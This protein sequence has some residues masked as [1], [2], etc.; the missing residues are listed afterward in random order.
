[1]QGCGGH[2]S[3][4]RTA[5]TTQRALCPL[6]VQVE[7][8][9]IVSVTVGTMPVSMTELSRPNRISSSRS[10]ALERSCR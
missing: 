3:W 4:H 1:M 10:S 6:P 5:W 8:V 9:M 2:A 7:R